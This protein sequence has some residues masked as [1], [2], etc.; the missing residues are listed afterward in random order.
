MALCRNGLNVEML[1]DIPGRSEIE[2]FCIRGEPTWLFDPES[3]KLLFSSLRSSF[4]SSRII[5]KTRRTILPTTISFG[6]A[7][8]S[9]V[10]T[11]WMRTSSPS[12]SFHLYL[13]TTLR[14]RWAVAIA[15]GLEF[16]ICLRFRSLCEYL[17]RM[18]APNGSRGNTIRYEIFN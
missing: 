18:L 6:W 14:R 5:P 2:P 9:R 8:M 3:L 10:P 7:S 16:L 1:D 4:A 17:F 11:C 12:T 15:H 13:S